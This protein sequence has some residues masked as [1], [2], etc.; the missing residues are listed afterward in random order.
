MEWPFGGLPEPDDRCLRPFEVGEVLL[1]Q[2]DHECGVGQSLGQCGQE[3]LGGGV[4][5][6][7]H[8]LVEQQAAVDASVPYVPWRGVLA[9]LGQ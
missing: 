3:R 8:R 6:T 1:L 5:Q 9:A 2:G 4:V 7:G